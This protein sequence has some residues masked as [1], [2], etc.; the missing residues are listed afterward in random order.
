MHPSCGIASPHVPL[1]AAPN[2]EDLAMP[3]GVERIAE[4]VRRRRGDEAGG[5]MTNKTVGVL[6]AGRMGSAMGHA[7]ARGRLRPAGLQPSSKEKAQE[8]AGPSDERPCV[9]LPRR[10]LAAAADVVI[11]M[12][13]DGAAVE[14]LYRGPGGLPGGPRSTDRG[15]RRQHGLARDDPRPR[16]ETSGRPAPASLTHLCR[17]A[18][19]SPEAGE[20]TLMV[21]GDAADLER[22]RPAGWRPSRKAHL[23][24]GPVGDRRHHQ[25]ELSTRSSSASAGRSGPSH[26]CW[27]SMRRN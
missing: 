2:L 23:P 19:R 24:H 16:G 15:R 17:E 4:T 26:S 9:R 22:A 3:F 25:A 10:D 13:S 7:I 6:G 27:P 11:S 14:A 18:S 12:V 20:L 1:A 5:A 8:L 21:G